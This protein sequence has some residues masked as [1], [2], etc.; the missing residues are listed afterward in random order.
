MEI[1]E[2]VSVL[3]KLKNKSDEKNNHMQL[4]LCRQAAVGQG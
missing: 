2:N 1:G 4:T 3:A